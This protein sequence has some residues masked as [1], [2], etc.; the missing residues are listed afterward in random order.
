ML[1]KV[2]SA[3]TEQTNILALNAAIEAARAG[4]HGKGF[5]IAADEVR[6]LAEESK[7]SAKQ[8]VELVTLIQQ[9]ST[10]SGK[11]GRGNSR[12]C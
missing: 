12:Q 5:A 9:E 1:P 2:I 8:I 11:G 3:I 4:E 10:R 7:E 6:K